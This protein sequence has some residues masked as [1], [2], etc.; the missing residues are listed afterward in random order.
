MRGML[1]IS[2]HRRRAAKGRSRT[3][4]F[5]LSPQHSVLSP[6]LLL[7][8]LLLAACNL[9]AQDAA[10][11]TPPPALP[12]AEFLFP[13]NEA[14]VEEGAEILVDILARDE[15]VGI[16]R[17]EF[18]VDDQL[19]NERGPDVS[20]AVNTFTVRMNW[21]AQGVGRHVFTATAYRPDGTQ[22]DPATILVNVLPVGTAA[23]TEAST[24]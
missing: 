20:A 23:A 11:A 16:A 17:V 2:T 14:T 6:F 3:A 8:V 5:S 12:V 24:P 1:G 18:H 15:G 10:T 21:L 19:I 9:S 22:S 13:P 4:R 7:L